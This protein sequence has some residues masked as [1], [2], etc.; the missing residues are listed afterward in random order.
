VNK[1]SGVEYKVRLQG[2]S[3]REGTIPISALIN[4]SQAILDGSRRALR[5]LMEGVSVKRGRATKSLKKPLNLTI[6]GLSIGST[7]LKIEAPT[8]EESAPEIVQ[9]LNLWNMPLKPE[10][11]P[12]DT[13]ISIFSKSVRDAS[14]GELE[15]D[16]YDRGVLES[17][18]LFKSL[19]RED[20]M[21]VQIE[22]PSRPSEDFRIGKPE[23]DT[24]TKIEAETPEPKAMVVVGT[25]NSIEHAHRRFELVMQNGHKIKGIAQ[26]GYVDTEDMRNLWGKKATVKGLAH[27]KP[28]GAIRSIEADVIKPFERGEELFERISKD[29]ISSKP[30]QVLRREQGI[31][32]PLKEV[33]GKWPGDESID[34]ILNTLKRTSRETT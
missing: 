24:I 32:N 11:K 6:T 23:L 2:L 19:L 1:L 13:V 8:F 22:C 12:K 34:E 26:S 4:V 33:W 14:A 20:L 10:L 5:L 17:L 18:E 21:A 16:Y 30:I 25:F 15:S 31:R 27:F 28:T 7:V 9:Q 29:R 3:T